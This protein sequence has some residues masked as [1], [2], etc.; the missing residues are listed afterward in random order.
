[1]SQ[2]WHDTAEQHS[3]VLPTIISEPSDVSTVKPVR[4]KKSRKDSVAH[5][6]YDDLFKGVS[7]GAGTVASL[8]IRAPSQAEEGKKGNKSVISYA[9]GQKLRP[10]E[11]R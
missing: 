2:E 11:E 1:L 9:M 8:P 10:F 5:G 4:S 3:V 7:Y 6:Q